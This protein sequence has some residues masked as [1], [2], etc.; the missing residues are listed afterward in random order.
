MFVGLIVKRGTD[1]PSMTAAIRT[2]GFRTLPPGE[3][4]ATR[5]QPEPLPLGVTDEQS[6]PT[7]IG[8]RDWGN[9]LSAAGTPNG[10]QEVL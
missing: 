9:V 6:L 8:A 5:R 3:H 1:L 7:G 2:P 10:D 4:R